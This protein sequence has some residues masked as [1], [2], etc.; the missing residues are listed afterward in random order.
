MHE[1]ITSLLV[2]LPNIHQFKKKIFT[3]RLS[4]K[5]FL[6]WLLT[7]PP[8]LKHV[9]TLPS[10]LSL[11]DCFAD[12]NVSQGSVATYARCGGIFDIH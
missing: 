3:C 5:P 1:T 6:L 9:A 11:M 4:N 10:N 7:T 12:I 2:T 8:H